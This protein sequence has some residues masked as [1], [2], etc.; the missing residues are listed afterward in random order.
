MFFRRKANN[1]KDRP[2]KIP[3][4]LAVIMDGN[5][6]WAKR[7]GLPRQAGHRAGAETLHQFIRWSAGLGIPYVTVYAFSTE[8]WQRPQKEV[9]SLMQL[10][11]DFFDKYKLELE[12]EGV[13]LHFFGQLEDLPAKTLAA[14]HEAEVESLDRN[15]IQVNIALSYGG[16]QEILQAAKVLA[17]DLASG[18]KDEEDLQVEDLASHLYLADLPDPDLLIRPG[19]EQRISN[20]LLWQLSY[21]ELYFSPKLWPDFTQDDLMAALKEFSARDRRFGGL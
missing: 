16:R 4:H 6:R 20:F 2:L 7:R 10:L 17:Q 13:R 21:T 14:A 8:N 9:D 18:K 12:R 19:G 1:I 11:I 5:G 3:Q 15:R